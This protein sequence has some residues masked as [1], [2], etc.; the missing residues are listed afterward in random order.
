MRYPTTPD[1]RYFVVNGK[2]WRLSDPALEHDHRQELVN[3]LMRARHAVKLALRSE[4][5]TALSK[6]RA[7]V[8]ALKMKLGERGPPW[9]T[10][11]APDFNR[12][13]VHD[14]PYA[15]WFARLGAHT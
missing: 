11:G 1:G 7:E 3:S 13:M 8:D 2:L 15:G 10:D 4:R 12:R 9:W 14:T 5:D 6:A